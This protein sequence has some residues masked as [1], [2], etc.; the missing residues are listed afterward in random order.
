MLDNKFQLS[1]SLY[2]LLISETDE[3]E[4]IPN[5]IT[6]DIELCLV[7]M[8]YFDKTNAW[9]KKLNCVIHIDDH[10]NQLLSLSKVPHDSTIHFSSLFTLIKRT[11]CKNMII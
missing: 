9:H 10:I 6:T 7:L 5:Y 11:H 3:I 4:S 8:K 1:K 2:M